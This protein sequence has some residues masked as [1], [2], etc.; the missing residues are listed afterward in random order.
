MPR[1]SLQLK[2]ACLR[3]AVA[4]GAQRVAFPFA[5]ALGLDLSHG[6][7]AVRG[8]DEAR[9]HAEGQDRNG[10]P[11]SRWELFTVH[12]GVTGRPGTACQATKARADPHGAGRDKEPEIS[13]ACRVNG[14][15]GMVEAGLRPRASASL[16]RFPGDLG[17]GGGR[18]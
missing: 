10:N 2:G 13:W 17:L 7:C 14:A 6:P 16:L 18:G 1:L 8:L 12:T 3:I 11:Q 15:V 9:V 4:E 5:L